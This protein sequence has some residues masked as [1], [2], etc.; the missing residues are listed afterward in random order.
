LSPGQ[1]YARAGIQP[2]VFFSFWMWVHCM[3]AVETNFAE[4][5]ELAVHTSPYLSGRKLRIETD[6]GRV[7]LHG[8]VRS[9]F[10][11]QMAQEALRRVDGVQGIDN[12][13]IV[14]A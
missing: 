8:T 4:R 14:V 11:K 7:V 12:R 2:G 3:S 6:Q 1:I 5:V 9:Y 13:L 10:Q